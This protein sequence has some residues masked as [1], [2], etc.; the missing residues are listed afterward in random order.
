MRAPLFGLLAISLVSSSSAI[1][2]SP[3]QIRQGF[4]ASA[5]LGFGSA[6]LTCSDLC[7][8]DRQRAPAGYLRLG[9]AVTPH[10]VLAGELNVWT[11]GVNESITNLFIDET[12]Q[13]LTQEQQRITG[14]VA[15]TTINAIA[16]WYPQ[17]SGGFFVVGGAGVGRYQTH[18]ESVGFDDFSAHT[19]ALGYQVGTGYDIRVTHALSVTP[20]ATYFGVARADIGIEPNIEGSSPRIGANALHVGLGLTWH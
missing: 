19:T 11:R 5:G 15:L 6:E 14:R 9:R 3:T 1:A 12:N 8:G 2:Q 10:L 17:T 13:I 7:G 16:Q 4:T 20:Y 18:V